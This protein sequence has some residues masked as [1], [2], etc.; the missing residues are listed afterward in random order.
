MPPPEDLPPGG[1]PATDL[2]QQW[3]AW[4]PDQVAERLAAV[5]APWYVAGGW[6]LDLY[7][8]EQTREHGDLEIGLPAAAFS[9]VRDALAGCQFEVAGSGHLW[10]LDSPAFALMHQ[11]WVSEPAAGRLRGRVYRL[12]VFREPAAGGRWVC[13]RDE[14]I[15]LPYDRVIGRDRA[16][17]PYL[18]PEITLLFKAKAARPKDEADFAAAL[19]LL[20]PDARGWLR[21]MLERVH[22]GHAWIGAL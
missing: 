13:R 2:S 11:V 17:I 7:R 16:G 21:Q 22:P 20:S 8:G 12:D 14:Q 18:M 4:R 19:P 10:P 5:T 3:E 15:V 9:E 1:I 6:A